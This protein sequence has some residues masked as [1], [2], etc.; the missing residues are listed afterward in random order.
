MRDHASDAVIVHVGRCVGISENI[1]RVEDVKAL[2][3]H[4]PEVEIINRDNVENVEIILAAVN[5][6]VPFHRR[7]ERVH[8]MGSFRKV[9]LAHPYAK[10]D[11]APTRRCEGVAVG[12]QVAR[13]HREQIAG[14]EVRVA[15]LRPMPAVLKI[16]AVDIVA[17]GKQHGKR[18][19]VRR[20]VHVVATENI[21]AIGEKSYPPEPLRF[22]L[23]AE[24]TSG[25]VEAHQ[26]GVLLG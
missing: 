8:C 10:V 14:L 26:L 25:C 5:I 19:L 13:D 12:F 16:A 15:P 7:F 3:L 23:G 11:L 20:H 1:A 6:F 17:V 2:V 21:G 24:Q 18:S 9:S 4:R 22:A